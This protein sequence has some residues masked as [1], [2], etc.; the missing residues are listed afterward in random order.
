MF[1]NLFRGIQASS[2]EYRYRYD[3]GFG[4]FIIE[5]TAYQY[6]WTTMCAVENGAMRHKLFNSFDAAHQ[7]AVNTGLDKVYEL[8]AEQRHL[9][10][11]RKKDEEHRVV[12]LPNKQINT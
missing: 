4:A 12:H 2:W 5:Y 9:L 11:K 10:E 8:V 1:K 7:F 6:A 3:S